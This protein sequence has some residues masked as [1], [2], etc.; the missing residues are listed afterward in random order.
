MTRAQENWFGTG[1]QFIRIKPV[2]D[3]DGSE[4]YQRGTTNVWSIISVDSELGQIYLLT[5]NTSPDNYGGH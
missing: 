5:G 2:L 4:R 3:A 1:T